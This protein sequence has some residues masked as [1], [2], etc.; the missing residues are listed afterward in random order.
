MKKKFY[1]NGKLVRTSENHNYTHAVIVVNDQG[2][3]NGLCGC[4]TS[5]NAAQSIISS[6]ISAYNRGIENCMSKVKAM[7]AGKN[8]YYCKDGRRGFYER[9]SKDE[10]VER[11][12]GW[13]ET[14]KQRIEWI[15]T[16]WKVVELTVNE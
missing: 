2:E 11:L 6:E 16:H 1:Y 7:Q 14:A 4:R 8:C 13:A 9:I 12:L 10:S 5:E 3:F 15:R